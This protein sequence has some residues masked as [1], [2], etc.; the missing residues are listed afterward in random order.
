MYCT[1][2]VQDRETWRAVVSTVMNMWF[3]QNVR[4]FMGQRGNY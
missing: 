2:L 3:A 1:D 4:N